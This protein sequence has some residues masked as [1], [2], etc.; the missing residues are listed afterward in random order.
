MK[1]LL[2]YFSQKGVLITYHSHEPMRA[3]QG[4][5]YVLS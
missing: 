1:K 3:S 5:H 2:I 4:G